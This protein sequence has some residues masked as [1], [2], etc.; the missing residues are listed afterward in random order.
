MLVRSFPSSPSLSPQPHSSFSVFPSRVCLHSDESRSVQG[1]HSKSTCIRSTFVT[2]VFFPSSVAKK[3]NDRPSWG[4]RKP[5]VQLHGRTSLTGLWTL[6]A[7][8][9]FKRESYKLHHKPPCIQ[10]HHGEKEGEAW[11]RRQRVELCFIGLF[12]NKK[13][14]SPLPPSPLSPKQKQR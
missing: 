12:M 6:F 10:S 1:T 13:S 4:R 14:G 11:G 8:H 7:L 2:F 5:P 9:L 3:K